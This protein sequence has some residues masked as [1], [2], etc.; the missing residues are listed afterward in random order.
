MALPFLSWHRQTNRAAFQESVHDLSH[1]AQIIEPREA[2]RS[3]R[4]QGELLIGAAAWLPISPAG[5]YQRPALIRQHDEDQQDLTPSDG[6]YYLQGPTL[7]RVPFAQDGYRARNVMVV[8]IVWMFCSTM[9]GMTGY[10]R[11]WRSGLMTRTL[12]T[13]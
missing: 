2:I 13:S 7:K 11:R 5:G 9:S 3:A 6:A 8:G 12:C 4:F 10:W 1:V